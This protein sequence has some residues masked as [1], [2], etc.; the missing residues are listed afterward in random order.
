M[1]DQPTRSTIQL[2]PSTVKFHQGAAAA[3]RVI[4]AHSTAEF[5]NFAARVGSFWFYVG[6]LASGE[7]GCQTQEEFGAF[8]IGAS[9]C[10]P[11]P[12]STDDTEG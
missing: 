8:Q 10:A 1:S 2:D 7:Y 3:A 6:A 5:P 9:T 12:P 11:Q 4:E